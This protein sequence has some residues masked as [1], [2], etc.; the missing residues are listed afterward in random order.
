MQTKL[1]RAIILVDDYD[2]AF[3]FYEK[4]FFCR[5][6]FDET[7]PSGQRLLHIAFSVTDSLGIW[8]LQAEGESQQNKIGKQTA[9]QPT[10]V[11]YTDDVEELYYHVQGNGVQVIEP[12]AT[13]RESKFFH[14]LD[15]YGNRLTIVEL[16]V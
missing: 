9:G 16:S 5:K 12:L 15:L 8:F 14:C 3:E 1:G 13:A 10:L 11:I 2:K 7:S 6:I 4:N